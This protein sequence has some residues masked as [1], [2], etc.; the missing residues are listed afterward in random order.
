MEM[1]DPAWLG[2][3]TALRELSLDIMADN[4]PASQTMKL[5]MLP[6]LVKLKV[7]LMDVP[8]QL[9]LDLSGLQSLEEL[10]IF[11]G[12]CSLQVAPGLACAGKLRRLT[13]DVGQL[14][15]DFA[16]LPAL[17]WATLGV[18]LD[19][20]QG[21]ASIAACSALSRLDLHAAIASTTDHPWAV[22]LIAN[23]P[24]SL[25]QLSLSNLW[26]AEATAAVGALTHLEGLSVST[27]RV[28][29]MPLPPEGSA[30]WSNLAALKLQC[31]NGALPLPQVSRATFRA[32]DLR[33]ASMQALL[34][35][36]GLR[37]C[38]S[39]LCCL[40]PYY[41]YCSKI[42]GIMLLFFFIFHN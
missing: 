32:A 6:G 12:C 1:P 13:V 22:E 8:V 33:A 5:P 35:K 3:L 11:S 10:T 30:V 34:L 17:E 42:C 24:S 26:A 14:S 37:G 21:A 23:V 15:L 4:T 18:S 38:T 7:D 31:S 39:I 25:R 20:L 40:V 41:T 16:E 27:W 28:D 9:H 2:Q 36:G 29:P 19:K